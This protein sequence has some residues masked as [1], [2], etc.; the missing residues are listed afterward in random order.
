MNAGKA[1]SSQGLGRKPD[2]RVGRKLGRG[3]G[4]GGNIWFLSDAGEDGDRRH[5]A[6]GWG[7]GVFEEVLVYSGKDCL[8]GKASIRS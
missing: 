3:V 2:K 1:D 4:E 6:V 8:P 7:W 5:F